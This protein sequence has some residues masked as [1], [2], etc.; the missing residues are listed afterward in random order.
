MDW[1]SIIIVLTSSIIAGVVAG[2]AGASAVM[3][4]V[5]ILMIF[6]KMDPYIVVGLTLLVDVAISLVAV[7]V[8][9]KNKNI[10][11]MS[12]LPILLASFFGVA[13]GSYIS[14]YIPSYN[15]SLL[16]GIGIIIVG[17]S[18]L[19]RKDKKKRTPPKIIA[20]FNK[21][22]KRKISFLIFL[23]IFIGF[24]SGA[25]GAGG[26]LMMFVVLVFIL[27][28]TIH[29]AI[30][31][32]L[33][34]MIFIAFFGGLSHFYYKPFSLILLGVGCIGGII[35]SRYSSVFANLLSEKQLKSAAG[36]LFLVLGV[37]LLMWSIFGSGSGI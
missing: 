28:Y 20:W 3:V 24:I 29:K 2:L 25:F 11:L 21:T 26:G 31:T 32:S 34:M 14:F 6:L 8:Y 7:K 37:V 9:Y 18:I 33:L 13:I 27:D 23:G 30:G 12:A 15:F 19:L 36:I 1:F 5:P 17:I 22:K 4:M 10:A 35:G 16:L